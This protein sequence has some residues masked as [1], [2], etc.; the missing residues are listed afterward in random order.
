MRMPAATLAV[1]AILVASPAGLANEMKMSTR[2]GAGPGDKALQD[3]MATMMARMHA[4]PTGDVDA[5][6]VTMMLPHH[7]GAVDM[8]KAELKYGKDPV[9]LRLA[10]DIVAAQDKEIALMNDWLAR[11]GK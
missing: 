8:A 9:L 5:D 7:L 2:A 11:R 6:F 4:K 10:A 1:L 3:S